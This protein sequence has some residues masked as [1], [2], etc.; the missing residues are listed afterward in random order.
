[1]HSDMDKDATGARYKCCQFLIIECMIPWRRKEAHLQ[2]LSCAHRKEVFAVL[3]S[4]MPDE[5]LG[6]D[7]GFWRSPIAMLW[8]VGALL[9]C[10][11]TGGRRHIHSQCVQPVVCGWHVSGQ[12]IILVS[13]TDCA[14][15]QRAEGH[16]DARGLS[17][18]VLATGC[19]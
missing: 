2:L 13:G 12:P 6:Q 8:P 17:S 19:R 1:M 3:K 18:W 4:T 5:M 9:L 10:S 16:Q 15:Q 7:N 14:S 11:A